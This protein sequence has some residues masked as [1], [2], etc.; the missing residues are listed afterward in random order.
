MENGKE[1][2]W[3]F[4]LL[5]Q[6]RIR[7]EFPDIDPQANELM[8][9]INRAS[10]QLIETLESDVHQRMGLTWTSY[11]FLF[12]LWI[13]GELPPHRIAAL[14]NT[15]RALISSTAASLQSQGLIEKRPSKTDGR[16]V[17]LLLTEAG[18]QLVR[19]AFAEQDICQKQ[20]LAGLTSAEQEILS[21]LL[22][23]LMSPHVP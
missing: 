19:Q 16:S 22:R 5:A 8:L 7:E 12:V 23:K 14:T 4:S 15:S 1:N 9:F 17:D 11:R 6:Q 13:C 21:I 2:Y 3:S 18:E 20:L 10:G